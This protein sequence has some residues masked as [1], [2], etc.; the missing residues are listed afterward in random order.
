MEKF[1]TAL[2]SR[3]MEVVCLSTHGNPVHPQKAIAEAV[4][5]DIIDSID[6]AAELGVKRIVTFS[7][8]PGDSEGAKYP[9][10]PVSPWPDDFQEI[11]KWQWEEVLI[12]YWKETG[13]YAEAKG[14]QIAL[15]LH[16]GFSVHTPYTLVKLR[17]ATSSAIGANLDPSHLWWQGIDPVAAIRYLGQYDALYYF[18]AKDTEINLNNAAVYGLT[19]MQSYAN[20][21]SRSWQFRTVGFGHDMKEW[22][23]ILST[24]RIAGYDDVI[25]IEHEDAMMS[26]NEGLEKAIAN[27]GP[28]VMREPAALPQMFSRTGKERA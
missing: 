16:G 28:L 11:L 19:D 27:L 6:L 8:C 20:I 7:G 24:L 23:D 4:H 14:V 3:E 12:P 21:A 25:S 10:W 18:H 5:R 26:P 13:A 22:A 17:E 1:K 9:N 2:S 15:E